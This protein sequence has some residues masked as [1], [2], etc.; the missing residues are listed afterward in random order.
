MGK[1][2]RQKEFSFYTILAIAQSYVWFFTLPKICRGLWPKI[3][4]NIHSYY[5]KVVLLNHIATTSMFVLY[6]LCI[7]PVYYLQIPFFEQFKIM[8][9]KKWPWL[10]EDIAKRKEFWKLTWKSVKLCAF[11]FLG[12]L[13]FATVVVTYLLDKVG[14]SGPSFDVEN[15]PTQMDLLRDNILLT[16]FHEL[17]FHLAHRMMHV[18]P[19]LYKYHKV[20]HEYKHNVIL[21]A[22]HF[23]PVDHIVSISM[24]V[25]LCLTIIQPHS[26]T[27]CQWGFYIIYTNCDDHVGYSFPFS[28][29]RWFPF[30]ATTSEHEF[31]HCMNLGCYS[32]KLDVFERLFQTNE[33]FFPW[34]KKRSMM[35]VNENGVHSKSQ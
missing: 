4:G 13:T 3:F 27:Q 35:I 31:H 22:E 23:H 6:T 11:S 33:R 32:S 17:L 7:I 15:W 5:L 21:A 8:P 24:P 18:Y 28:A 20:H 26:F 14:I 10:E 1:V 29:V 19:S 25:L 12:V 9:N 34:E 30:A 16:V 2:P